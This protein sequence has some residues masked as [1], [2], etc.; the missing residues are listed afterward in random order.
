MVGV[1]WN[2]FHGSACARQH[3]MATHGRI[4]CRGGGGYCLDEKDDGSMRCCHSTLLLKG[5]FNI[6]GHTCR[7]QITCIDCLESMEAF[8][9]RSRVI[10][11]V[12]L[13]GEYS[14]HAQQQMHKGV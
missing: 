13:L 14:R 7:L 1:G 3:V 10:A 4:V 6:H 12:E 5:S 11:L 2:R 8:G 9:L